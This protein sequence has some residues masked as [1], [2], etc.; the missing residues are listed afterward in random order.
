VCYSPPEC[1]YS[2]L[3]ELFADAQAEFEK[4]GIIGT[5]QETLVI[6][7]EV[8]VW[9]L[10]VTL[11]VM[12]T[13]TFPFSGDDDEETM[14]SVLMDQPKYPFYLSVDSV[15]LLKRLMCKEPAERITMEEVL[16]HAWTR[17]EALRQNEEAMRAPSPSTVPATTPRGASLLMQCSPRNHF[18]VTAV[19]SPRGKRLSMR[20]ES[21]A[22]SDLSQGSLR[23]IHNAS[24][25]LDEDDVF[26]P[27]LRRTSS[28][29]VP[30]MMSFIPLSF[31]VAN[32][33]EDG[34]ASVP[35]SPRGSQAGSAEQRKEKRVYNSRVLSALNKH[36]RTLAGKMHL[37]K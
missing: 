10:G 20:A 23:S 26:P 12:L 29:S 24:P 14:V 31:D 21:P 11:F 8:D 9:A 19:E 22:W 17:E 16:D 7:P 6:G 15:R 13:G 2:E 25:A 36:F 1:F 35:S 34:V 4:L 5:D 27:L 32:S 18:A 28:P 33:R 30:S 3:C 37:G